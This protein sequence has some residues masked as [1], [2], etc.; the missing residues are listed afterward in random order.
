[1]SLAEPLYT[2][3]GD[4]LPRSRH[5]GAGLRLLRSEVG[6]VFRRRRNQVLLAVLALIPVLIGVAIRVASS[7]P[8]AGEGPQFLDRVAGN[9][10]YLTFTALVVVLPLFLPLAVGIVAGDAVA[11]EADLGTL[12]Y[13]LTVPVRRA[14]LLVVKYAGLLAFT[15]AAVLAVAVTGA[16]AGVLMFGGGPVTL[17]SGDTVGVGGALLRTLLVA[18]YVAAGLVGLGAVGLFVSTLTEVPV[19]AMAGT[20]GF[21]LLSQVLGA[22]PQLSA[23]HPLLLSHHW[24]AFGDLLREP[25]PTGDLTAGMLLQ[26][27]YVAIFGAL[28]WSRFGTRDVTG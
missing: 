6:M 1:M 4:P 3:P 7:G 15:L 23:I 11:G 10:L 18:L 2:Y 26:L 28:A 20:V 19:A 13:L 27:S 12:R 14:R 9:G 25:V 21:A 5:P 16:V 17:L 24:L 22:V 8:A